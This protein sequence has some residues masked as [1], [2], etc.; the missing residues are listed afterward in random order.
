MKKA[1]DTSR[2]LAGFSLA[3]LLA[4]L[5]IGAMILVAMLAILNRA[6]TAAAAIT[7]RLDSSTLPSEVL[8]R[9]AEDLDGILAAGSDT[10]ITIENKTEMHGYTT[11]RMTILKTVYNDKNQPQVFEEI[12]WQTSYDYYSGA[13][14]LVLYR[15]HSGIN[16]EDKL[17]D[18]KRTT[19]EAQYPFVP[20]CAGVTFFKIQVPQGENLQNT[21]TSDNLPVGIMVT[22]SLAE[23]FATLTNIWDVP[24]TD[25]ISRTIAIDRTRKIQFKIVKKEDTGVEP[26]Q[27]KGQDKIKEE[28]AGRK[29]PPVEEGTSEQ[30]SNNE[31]PQLEKQE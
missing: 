22:I 9:I 18:E 16:L 17:L 29:Q 14:G 24:Q 2:A 27:D 23:P 19:L 3:E 7:R 26:G 11:A 30:Q 5:T 28:Q 25:K 21:W 31:Q 10:K 6:Q 12:I 1:P 13:D 20:I 4:A 15:S 8:Q